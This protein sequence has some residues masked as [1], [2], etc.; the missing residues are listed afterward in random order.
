MPGERA[1]TLQALKRLLH[2]VPD[3]LRWHW[4]SDPDLV[5]RSPRGRRWRLYHHR[6]RWR[7]R[8]AGDGLIQSNW[9]EHTK[10][11]F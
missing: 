5:L 1:I 4:V 7:L 3:R 2:E 6:G 9:D 8:P 11:K 10:A